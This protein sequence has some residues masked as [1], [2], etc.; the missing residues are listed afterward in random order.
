MKRTSKL[1]CET[2]VLFIWKLGTQNCS[3]VIFCYAAARQFFPSL[4][5]DPTLTSHDSGLKNDSIVSE[6]PGPQLSDGIFWIPQKNLQQRKKR[7][8]VP[9]FG[10]IWTIST[11]N[12]WEICEV[13]RLSCFIEFFVSFH[14]VCGRYTSILLLRP[15][16]PH[17]GIHTCH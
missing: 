1:P 5:F 14:I 7:L 13:G 15:L 3:R 10:P 8:R 12:Q 4:N 17:F 9:I 11:G 6:S 16:S 2:H